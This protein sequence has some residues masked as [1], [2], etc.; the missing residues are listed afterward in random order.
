MDKEES[1][2]FNKL[3]TYISVEFNKII[4]KMYQAG[5]RIIL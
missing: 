5:K 4:K 3:M 1:I 2:I